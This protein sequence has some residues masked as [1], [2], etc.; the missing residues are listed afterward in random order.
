MSSTFLTRLRLGPMLVDAKGVARLYEG[1]VRRGDFI[2][3][4]AA[5]LLV[6]LVVVIVS[7]PLHVIFRGTWLTL[8]DFWLDVTGTF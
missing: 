7:Q 2:L 6:V 5:A 4:V 1:N 8:R 3:M